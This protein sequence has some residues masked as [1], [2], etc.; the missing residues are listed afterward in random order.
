MRALELDINEDWTSFI[1]YRY[2]GAGEPSNLLPEMFRPA[3]RYLTPD[4]R[5]FFAVYRKPRREAD[6]RRRGGSAPGRGRGGRWRL[7]AA[8]A[9]A[10]ALLVLT[11]AAGLGVV[12]VDLPAAAAARPALDRRRTARW[13]RLRRRR[14]RAARAAR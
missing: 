11:Q 6:E 1:T 9:A 4:E 2:P 7:D 13:A 5:D 14:R 3:S 10:L 8:L 12:A